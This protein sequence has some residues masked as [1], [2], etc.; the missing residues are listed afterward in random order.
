MSPA[1]TA[2]RLAYKLADGPP[3]HN[4]NGRFVSVDEQLRAYW[5]F[6]QHRLQTLMSGRGPVPSLNFFE[7]LEAD[8]SIM[9]TFPT[10]LAAMIHAAQSDADLLSIVGPALDELLVERPDLATV[11]PEVRS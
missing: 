8:P 6:A 11:F 2:F 1:E 9:T 7:A 10:E 3:I 5:D 4:F